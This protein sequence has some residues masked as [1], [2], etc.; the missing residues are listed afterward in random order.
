MGAFALAFGGLLAA[1]LVMG[2]C[3]YITGERPTVVSVKA[4][5]SFT[6]KGSGQLAIFT[7]YSPKTGNRIAVPH[8]DDSSIVWQIVA[9]N[10]YFEGARVGGLELNY[11]K[12]P[13]DY[14]QL[15]PSES[16]PAPTLPAGAVYSFFAETTNAPVASGYFYMD[17]KGPIQTYVP[18]LCL[19]RKDGH[20]IR[21]KCGFVGD[22]TYREPANLE[23]EV[24]KNQ[25]RDTGEAKS[26]TE[27]EPCEPKANNPK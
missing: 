11:G 1:F 25:I 2:S 10:G 13:R 7:V 16:Q 26:F 5:P 21:V 4:G 17:A 24:H 15:V 19:T 8:K 23:D 18:D 14:T 6:M 12:V 22:R 3:F 20:Q 9:K 27:L